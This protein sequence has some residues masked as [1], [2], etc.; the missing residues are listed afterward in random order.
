M[1][2]CPGS[3]PVMA[4]AQEEV[5]EMVNIASA[6]VIN[7]GTLSEHW[8]YSMFKAVTQ[9]RKNGI[10]IIIDPVGAGDIFASSFFI[11]YAATH[12]PWE[13]ARVAT[14]IAARSV[15]RKSLSGVPTPVEVQ[16][17]LMEILQ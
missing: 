12:D 4:H 5:E 11:R 14:Q 3:H 10:P 16:S 7:I 2:S 13:S 1:P 6:L 17:T 15:T 8:I 9:A